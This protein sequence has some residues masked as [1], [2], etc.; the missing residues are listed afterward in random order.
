MEQPDRAGWIDEDI[1]PELTRITRE[2]SSSGRSSSDELLRVGPP[3]GW[4]PDVPCLAMEHP[5]PSI[6][7]PRLVDQNRPPHTRLVRVRAGP[8]TPLERH[9][10]DTGIE[11]LKGAFVLLQLQQMPA[12]R[13]ST[14]VPMEHQQQPVP[15]VVFEAVET[16]FL[17]WQYEWH[18]G[19][20][21]E[22]A[23]HGCSPA[24]A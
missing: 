4:A 16:A 17:V 21:D 7:R 11:F 19:T 22:R 3:H 10:D 12:A 23:F 1:A 24:T 14:Q 2:V 13:Q 20:T 9:H 15:S 5:V 8:W 18:R 6:E